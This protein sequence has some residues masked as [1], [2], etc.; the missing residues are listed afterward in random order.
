MELNNLEACKNNLINEIATNKRAIEDQ[1]EYAKENNL[2][3]DDSGYSSFSTWFTRDLYLFPTDMAVGHNIGKL[4]DELYEALVV[5][6]RTQNSKEIFL[7]PPKEELGI[8]SFGLSDNEGVVD[9]NVKDTSWNIGSY[10]IRTVVVTS[11]MKNTVRYLEKNGLLKYFEKSKSA[12]DVEYVKLATMG[13]LYGEKTV[14]QSAPVLRRL[15]E[16][17]HLRC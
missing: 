4:T 7:H 9:K 10:D 5:D 17:E 3:F 8:I 15:L 2:L 12:D 13:Q 11:G 1:R 14:G 6:M 16:Q